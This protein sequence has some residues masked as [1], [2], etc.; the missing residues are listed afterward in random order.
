MS[1]FDD[2][3]GEAITPH[4]VEQEILRLNRKLEHNTKQCAA[5][6]NKVSET[7]TD[8]DI[9]FHQAFAT[10]KHNGASEGLAKAEAIG[11]AQEQLKAKNAALALY[12]SAK[13]EGHNIRTALDSLRSI[14]ANARYSAGLSS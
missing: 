7:D 8:Y 12:R 4:Q 1:D 10:A 6:A 3:D 11:A 14:N 5:R 9:V 13:E 2:F